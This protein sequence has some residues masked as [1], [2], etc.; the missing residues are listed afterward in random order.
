MRRTTLASMESAP[1]PCTS[2][3]TSPDRFTVPPITASP[4]CLLTSMDSPVIMLS[5]AADRPTS[6]RPSAGKFAPGTTLSTSPSCSSA[7]STS[8][9]ASAPAAAAANA[10]NAGSSA[11]IPTSLGGVA[12]RTSTTTAVEGCSAASVRMASEVRPLA[13]AS[14]HLPSSTKLMSTA[15]VSKLGVP[16]VASRGAA[17]P[18]TSMYSEWPYAADVPSATSRSMLADRCRSALYART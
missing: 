16:P 4:G 5:S 3:S 14:S 12:P 9:S 6:T 8:S 2:T 7:V 13:R 11:R 15:G 18:A 1:T 17:A 10:A